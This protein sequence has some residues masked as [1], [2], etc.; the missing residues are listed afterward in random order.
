[1]DDDLKIVLSTELE[2]DEQASAQRISAQLPSIAKMVNAGSKIKIQVSLDDAKVQ[3]EAQKITK[4]LGQIAKTHEVGVSVSLNQNSIRKIQAEL[5]A[6]DVNP[7]ISRAMADQLDRMGVQVDKITGK[8]QEVAGAEEKLLNLSIQGTDQLGRTVSYLQTYSTATGE[9]DTQLTNVTLNL[10]KQR[11]IEEQI[12]NRAKS[13]NEARIAY[14]TEQQT[15]L[16]KIESTYLGL[17]SSK[18]VQDTGHL[19]SIYNSYDE[20]QDKISGLMNAEIGRASCR[21][22]V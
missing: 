10:E 12:A 19:M 20:L 11:N 18:P 21:E 9:V 14:L 22:R 16:Q 1:M 4:Q 2:A 3:S 8:W 6:L 7:D 15:A 17:T 5:K 13:D